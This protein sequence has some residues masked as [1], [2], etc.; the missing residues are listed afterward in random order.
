MVSKLSASFPVYPDMAVEMAT[1]ESTTTII[2][3]G[4]DLANLAAYEAQTA[5]GWN[6]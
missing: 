6:F 2:E 1:S 3:D 5:P 4:F